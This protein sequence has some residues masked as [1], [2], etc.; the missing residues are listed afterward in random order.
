MKSNRS[1]DFLPTLTGKIQNSCDEGLSYL[2]LSPGCKISSHAT[3]R[4]AP[5]QHMPSYIIFIML[6]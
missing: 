1:E 6:Q 4:L 2:C 5:Y 3:F